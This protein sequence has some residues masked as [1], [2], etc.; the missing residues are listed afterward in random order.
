MILVLAWTACTGGSAS[1]DSVGS[2]DTG[3]QPTSWISVAAG[4]RS[5]CGVRNDGS[6][7]C[8]GDSSLAAETDT[9]AQYSYNHEDEPPDMP[10]AVFVTMSVDADYP[11]V[12]SGR[13]CAL[14]ADGTVTCW[15]PDN[16]DPSGQ[17]SVL[18][19]GQT[20]ECGI[21][22]DRNGRCWAE[23]AGWSP[24]GPMANVGVRIG[25]VCFVDTGGSVT[26]G[27]WAGPWTDPNPPGP[28]TQVIPG[29][30]VTCG[31]SSVGSLACWDEAT[32]EPSPYLIPPTDREPYR[33]FC[34]QGHELG[35]G[36]ALDSDGHAECFGD[37]YGE[38]PILPVPDDV[39]FTSLSCGNNHACGITPDGQ[40][41]C[42]GSDE[43]GQ[44]DVPVLGGGG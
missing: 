36:C 21:D 37:W 39:V 42:F 40:A 8:W 17:L 43:F 18:S 5:S 2:G 34:L 13:S 29:Y 6:V 30:G 15:A 1:K 19:L 32:A 3:P 41:V 7:E 31:L 22:L 4:N 14:A 27:D 24:A 9:G 16:S 28:Y 44:S 25:S 33:S 38:S 35:W 26:C 20:L 12:R 10:P 23:V 11:A